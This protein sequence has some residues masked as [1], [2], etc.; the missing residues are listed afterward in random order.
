M[1]MTIL[2]VLAFYYLFIQ[3]KKFVRLR[4]IDWVVIIFFGVLLASAI[5][6]MDFNR[7]F[8]GEQSRSQGVFT[9]LHFL[10]FYLLLRQFF[11]NLGSFKRAGI[12]I[13]SISF[14]SSM[15]AWFG[16]YLPFINQYIPADSRISGLIG[17]PIALG[18]Y[19]MIPAFLAFFW[20]FYGKHEKREGDVGN[21]KSAKRGGE[22]S[23]TPPYP[24]LIKG[25]GEKTITLIKGG[26][27]KP[28]PCQGGKQGGFKKSWPLL[29]AGIISLITIIGT[30]TRGPFVGLLAGILLIIILYLIF[31]AS[32]KIKLV[33][34]SVFTVCLLFVVAGYF[35]KPVRDVMP[36]QISYIYDIKPSATTA[37][38]RFMAWDIALKGWKDSPILGNGAQTYQY[39]Y[40]KYYNPKFLAVSFE[41]TV[42]DIPHNY[43]LEVLGSSGIIGLLAYLTIIFLVFKML[44]RLIRNS[45]YESKKISF[46]I[47]AGA[48]FAYIVQLQFSFE[49]SNSL[50]LWLFVLAFV[51]WL[52]HET[53]EGD[54]ENLSTLTAIGQSLWRRTKAATRQSTKSAKW[55]RF[56]APPLNKGG[57][58]GGIFYPSRILFPLIIALAVISISQSY[59]MLKS[60]YKTN[61]ARVSAVTQSVNIWEERALDAIKT[62]VPFHW[63]Q[64][65]FLT[66]DLMEFDGYGKLSRENIDQAGYEIEKILVDKIRKQPE[67]YVYKFWLGQLYVLM[68]E[69]VDSNYYKKAENVLIE[70]WEVNKKRQSIMLTLGKLY[71]LQS[72]NQEAID[73]LKELVANNPDYS[74]PHWFLGLVL[75][76]DGQED[77]GFA[78]L[79]K[80]KSFAFSNSTSLLYLIDEYAKREKYEDI[81]I[82][83]EMLLGMEPSN[84][85]YYLNL[86]ATY[87][88]LGNV[89]KV[90][91]SLNKAVELEPK[92]KQSALQ[93]LRDN[94]IDF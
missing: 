26:G 16:L 44:W 6:G 85:S 4:A 34:L 63:H 1:L 38:T 42:W 37:Q 47:L 46:I 82:F 33:V 71:F 5:F 74:E 35:S 3:K 59:S 18:N 77:E 36:K 68:G 56:F 72:K 79:E 51:G 89:N 70:A 58:G 80:G 64:A 49:S 13:L 86:A 31:G 92:F 7:S 87:M 2:A 55:W 52:E 43:I 15:I 23:N 11:T 69:Y 10:L 19:L 60:S 20:F 24:P 45:K 61:L 30:Q 48:V 27:E 9:L 81:I 73:I 84:A 94:G 83:Y 50:H 62:P 28:P 40:D 57:V 67:I 21:T 17:N 65:M 90:I 93:F 29:I 22:K 75:M 41:E 88:E 54:V 25:G 91:E 76:S 66:K 53:R 14:I 32:K 39:V 8:W 78:E 12:W